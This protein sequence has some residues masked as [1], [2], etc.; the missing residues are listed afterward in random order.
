MVSEILKRQIHHQHDECKKSL[1]ASGG[2]VADDIE[3]IAAELS[4]L[5]NSNQQA[6]LRGC[7]LWHKTDAGKLL[8]HNLKDD[9]FVNLT[10]EEFH[11][12]RPQYKQF[13]MKILRKYIYQEQRKQKEMPMKVT[14][15]IKLAKK[16]Q[17]RR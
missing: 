6:P 12:L 16:R 7:P 3:I 2:I 14:K 1:E 9:V 5:H 17:N 13:P 11:V 15:C 4:A 8:E 10:V